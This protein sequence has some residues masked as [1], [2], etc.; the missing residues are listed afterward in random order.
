M[1]S[2]RVLR[3]ETCKE[4]AVTAVLA[5]MLGTPHCYS[6]FTFALFL[7]LA[8]AVRETYAFAFFFSS[9]GGFALLSR[10]LLS[11]FVFLSLFFFSILLLCQR[12][13]KTRKHIYRESITRRRSQIGGNN[14]E[15]YQDLKYTSPFR[16][17]GTEGQTQDK[18]QA[19]SFLFFFMVFPC[20]ILL[21]CV[22]TKEEKVS[23]D[24]FA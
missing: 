10:V 7:L 13:K 18:R 4:S 9:G 20:F 21:I 11:C 1:P 6:G 8:L 15:A 16:A 14:T 19:L 2:V 24:V 23:T 12:E 5:K 22:G 3:R 17:P